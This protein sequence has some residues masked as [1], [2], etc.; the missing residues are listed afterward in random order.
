MGLQK[1]LLS[2]CTLTG[3]PWYT[4]DKGQRGPK[5]QDT[6]HLLPQDAV[7]ATDESCWYPVV[8]FKSPLAIASQFLSTCEGSTC[9]LSCAVA[10][11]GSGW[12][13]LQQGDC[14]AVQV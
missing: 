1:Y 9:Q 14:K 3:A 2:V 13:P 4:M 10:A 12:H 8:G 6:Q 7:A 5:H 11:G